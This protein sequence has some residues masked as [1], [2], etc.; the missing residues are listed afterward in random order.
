[1]AALRDGNER[2]LAGAALRREVKALGYRKSRLRV[3]QLLEHP[4][5]AVLPVRVGQLLG[6]CRRLGRAATAR[7]VAAAG[8]RSIAPRLRVRDLRGS[9]RIK[10]AA[11]LR[12]QVR[13][14]TGLDRVE[15]RGVG[16]RP[17]RD[18]QWRIAAAKSSGT[19]SA[20]VAL[21][22]EL[23]ALSTGRRPLGSPRW[24]RDRRS[25]CSRWASTTWWR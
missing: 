12:R 10:L 4:P 20:R 11:T 3:A 5:P 9:E 13:A 14:Y 2:R 8:V 15:R 6:A 7:L 25:S 23:K 17:A 19:R 16:G 21:R 22:R 18:A 24:S 1:M